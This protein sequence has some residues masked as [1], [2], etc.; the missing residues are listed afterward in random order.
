MS[1][2]RFSR[3]SAKSVNLASLSLSIMGII[4]T[5]A[6]GQ[7]ITTGSAWAQ[8]NPNVVP[9]SESTRIL[10]VRDLLPLQPASVLGGT[11]NA[12]CSFDIT[13]M[14]IILPGCG[15]GPSMFDPGLRKQVADEINANPVHQG[16]RETPN[17][18]LL[19]RIPL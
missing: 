17:D 11:V 5:T 15:A 10:R 4:F 14:G 2:Q 12:K 1:F 9:T 18:R 7:I 3:S 16:N 19:I 8:S 6:I 13:A